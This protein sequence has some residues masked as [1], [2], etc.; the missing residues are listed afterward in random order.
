MKL[1][2]SKPFSTIYGASVARY[3]QNGKYFAGNGDEVP[4][5]AAAEPHNLSAVQME[6]L[7]RENLE[8]NEDLN[9]EQ[10]AET[11]AVE[12]DD[13]EAEHA[14]AEQAEDTESTEGPDAVDG[15]DAED[16]VDDEAVEARFNKMMELHPRTLKDMAAEQ[17]RE[18][19]EAG[20]AADIPAAPYTGAGSKIKNAR[21]LARYVE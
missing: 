18:F 2:R 6:E 11:E 12:T 8:L 9:D 3:Y 14:E 20:K 15:S 7:R 21:W 13:V 10:G 1:N 19:K 17:Y 16:A 5:G 4:A